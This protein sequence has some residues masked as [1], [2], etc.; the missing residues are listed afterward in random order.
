MMAARS[1][2]EISIDRVVELLTGPN[3]SD[4]AQRHVVT[5]EQ[6]CRT[7]AAGFA[8]QDLKKINQVLQITLTAVKNGYAAFEEPLCLLLRCVV[9]SYRQRRAGLQSRHK[10]SGRYYNRV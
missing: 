9:V 4:L 1:G 7:N 5:I 6:L 8:V 2:P 3:S 10:T